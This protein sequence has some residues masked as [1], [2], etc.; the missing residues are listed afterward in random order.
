MQRKVRNWCSL[1]LGVVAIAGLLLARKPL[2]RWVGER[3][4][5]SNPSPPLESVEALIADSPDR[6]AAI[7]A[8]WNTGRIVQREVAVRMLAHDRTLRERL[9]PRLESIVLAGAL[10]ADMDVRETCL[11][12]L[13]DRKD[14][15][16]VPLVV[17]QLRDCDPQTCLLGLD[18]LKYES[19]GVGVPSVI[20]LLDNPEPQVVSLALKL[21]EK[22]SGEKFGVKISDT[23]LEEDGITGMLKRPDGIDVKVKSGVAQA[24]IW[25]GQHKAEFPPARLELPREAVAEQPALTAEDFS[26]RD[27]DGRRVRLSDFRGKVVLINFWTTWCTACLSEMPELIALQKAHEKDLAILGVSLDFVPTDDGDTD[28]NVPP[29]KVRA[30]V[31]RA[32]KARGI[33]YRVLLDEHYE[34]GGR[35][36]GGELPTTVILDGNGHVRRRF[37]GAREL[38]V[39]EAM[40]AEAGRPASG[41]RNASLVQR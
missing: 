28:P 39:F 23:V 24:R 5:L 29:E 27:L 18:Y 41:K 15:A 35:F 12:I 17:A 30:N 7:V 3:A 32:A 25:W 10:D 21:L 40:I 14:P 11:G 20:P 9:S 13:R 22:W 6:E 33:N 16:L 8:A 34:V 1:G 36:N 37:I 31:A 4:V 19:P 38:S 2:T 26:L